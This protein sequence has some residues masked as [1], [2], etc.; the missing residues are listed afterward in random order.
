V[1]GRERGKCWER[2][3][4]RFGEILDSKGKVVQ[5]MMKG[6]GRGRGRVVRMGRSMWSEVWEGCRMIKR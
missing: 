4:L 5:G 1:S 2:T 6:K 3:R